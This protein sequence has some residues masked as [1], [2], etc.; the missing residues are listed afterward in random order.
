MLILRTGTGPIGIVS[1]KQGTTPTNNPSFQNVYTLST[2]DVPYAFHH[3]VSQSCNWKREP[4]TDRCNS[5]QG[6]R[7]LRNS[8][9]VVTT[10][11][12]ILHLP[13]IET[14]KSAQKSQESF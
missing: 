3:A 4:F 1:L 5:P 8:S 12:S 7:S 14:G 13:H 11:L 2:R 9:N 6:T 10:R